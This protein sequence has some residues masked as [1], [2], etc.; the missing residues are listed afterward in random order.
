MIRTRVGYAGGKEP[1]PTYREIGDHS[2]TLQVDFD[3]RQIS[4]EALLEKFWEGYDPTEQSWSR[5]YMAAVLYHD[6]AQRRAAEASRARLEAKLGRKIATAILP[7][8]AF[9]LAEDYH[10]KYYLRHDRALRE[11]I[12]AMYPADRDFVNSTAAARANGILGGYGTQADRETDLL[13]M[14]LSPEAQERLRRR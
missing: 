6:D 11:E 8:G 10:Q 12:K 1:N 9:T 13:R 3:P 4:Y 5:Q 2:E 7:L 14:G